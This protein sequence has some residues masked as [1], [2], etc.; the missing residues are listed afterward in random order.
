MMPNSHPEYHNNYMLRVAFNK[1]SKIERIYQF[2]DMLL[3]F[4][5]DNGDW[6]FPL[7]LISFCL[8]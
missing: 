7:T 8:A 6:F 3:R 1:G 5:Q 4:I 2:Y